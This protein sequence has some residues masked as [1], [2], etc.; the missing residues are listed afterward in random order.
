MADEDERGARRGELGFEPFD[1][2]QIEM[3]GRLVEKQDVRVGGHHVREGRAADLSAR[4][5]RRIFVAGEPKL[6]QQVARLIG[7]V[8][9]RG[10]AST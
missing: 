3:V 4:E 2:G 9:G 8:G 6:L 10:P 1:G 5:V 7:I